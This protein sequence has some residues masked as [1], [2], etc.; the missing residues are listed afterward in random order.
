MQTIFNILLVLA[1]YIGYTYYR[2]G[3]LPNIPL[4]FDQ[5]ISEQGPDCHPNYSGCLNPNAS[6]YDCEGGNGNGPYYTGRVRVLGAD[7]FRLD[8]DGDGIACE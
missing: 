4:S 8:R 6:D 2:T 1:L 3:E 5:P 7:V